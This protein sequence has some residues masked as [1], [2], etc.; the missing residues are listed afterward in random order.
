[1]RHTRVNGAQQPENVC[2]EGILYCGTPLPGDAL[3][4]PNP[5]VL[6]EILSPS[7]ALQDL[8]DKLE[9]YFRVPSIAHYLIVDPDKRMII[10]H[11]RGSRDVI[12]TR[13]VGE[14]ALRLDRPGIEI[15]AA[16]VLGA[17]PAP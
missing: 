7:N 4:V 17:P 12:A 10:P 14:G 2:Q 8:R 3:E 1:L 15:A 9:G 11:A 13:L 16:D 5:V 6:V